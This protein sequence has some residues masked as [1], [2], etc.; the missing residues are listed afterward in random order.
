MTVYG[1]V[2]QL[3]VSTLLSE[4][5]STL[6]GVSIATDRLSDMRLGRFGE[7][8]GSFSDSRLSVIEPAGGREPSGGPR[9]P[10]ESSLTGFRGSFERDVK[11]LTSGSGEL[12]RLR[13]GDP[14]VGPEVEEGTAEQIGWAWIRPAGRSGWLRPLVSR[15]RSPAQRSR[16]GPP[17]ARG[18]GPGPG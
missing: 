16:R 14:R 18:A 4:G 6:V 13:V 12:F 2:P 17:P 8:R 10:A 5:Y 11:K 3:L 15:G 1:T 7:D 9:R